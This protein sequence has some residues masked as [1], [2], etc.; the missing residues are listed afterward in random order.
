MNDAFAEGL[1]GLGA[2]R[3]ES[4][5]ASA[6]GPEELLQR[7]LAAPPARRRSE[8]MR[9]S[10]AP[11]RLGIAVVGAVAAAAL[12]VLVSGGDRGI[13]LSP[14][15]A[16]A[17]LKEFA[18]A[19]SAH[20]EQEPPL[21]GGQ[22][23]YRRTQGYGA[24]GQVW[25]NRQGGGAY[26]STRDTPGLHRIKHGGDRVYLGQTPLDYERMLALPR[27]PAALLAVVEKSVLNDRQRRGDLSLHSE[28]QVFRAVEDFLVS[29]PAPSDLKDSFYGALAKLRYVHLIGPTRNQIGR[30]G[31]AVGMWFNG[32]P[33]TDETVTASDGTVLNERDDLI[34]DS[35][36]GALIGTRTV[37]NGEIEGMA[38]ETGV[39]D[40]IGQV[41][42]DESR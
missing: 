3:E 7:I 18:L 30:Q 6:I 9:P 8:R 28:Q 29:A 13:P 5:G 23:Y 31:I 22:F 16:S 33:D 27:K 34:F 36:T 10:I 41:P 38:L 17:T 1:R 21:E 37:L 39:V 14:P 24:V 20:R 25:T 4:I 19:A 42:R 11:R 26:T 12:A 35:R 15:S 2:A 32:G 40:R